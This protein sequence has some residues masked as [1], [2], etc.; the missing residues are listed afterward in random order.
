MDEA[1]D[2]VLRHSLCNTLGS[3]YVYVLKIEIP[4]MFEH[5]SLAT[6]E[7]SHTW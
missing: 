6:P 4:A 2:I 5:K 1:V 3:F 7:R